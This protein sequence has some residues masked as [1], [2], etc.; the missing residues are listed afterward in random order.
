METREF[1]VS[2]IESKYYKFDSKRATIL[3]Q[4]GQ[5]KLIDYWL[6]KALIVSNRSESLNQYLNTQQN[7][8]LNREAYS[9]WKYLR[10]IN[11]LNNKHQVS[12]VFLSEKEG[13]TKG[14]IIKDSLKTYLENLIELALNYKHGPKEYHFKFPQ[15]FSNNNLDYKQLNPRD[16]AWASILVSK[17]SDILEDNNKEKWD[18]LQFKGATIIEGLNVLERLKN[19]SRFVELSVVDFMVE[20]VEM[21]SGCGFT[22]AEFRA[23]GEAKSIHK[24]EYMEIDIQL[25][26]RKE[27]D[28]FDIFYGVND[29]NEH[30]WKPAI[31]RFKVKGEK[32]GINKVLGKVRIKQEGEMRWLPFEYE[33]NVLE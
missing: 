28:D 13:L 21:F 11:N 27:K 24:D 29:S 31:G 4:K 2:E 8:L 12:D 19:F 10:A 20:K 25:I 17:Y 14:A 26:L 9:S 6:S 7:I 30:N 22:I 5:T 32:I 33:F 1:I 15:Y 16:T 18:E 23:I 3:A